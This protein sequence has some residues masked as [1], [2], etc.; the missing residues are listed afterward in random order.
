MIEGKVAR[1]LN[2]R[3]LVINRGARNGVEVGMKFAVLDKKAENI[4]DPETGEVLGSVQ[5]PKIR[6]RVIEVEDRMSVAR[7]YEMFGGTRG[8]GTVDLSVLFLGEP[9][10]PRSLKTDETTWAPITEA[11]SFVKTGD[12]V[13]QVADV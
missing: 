10:R 7:T 12:S 6:V 4:K 3:E 13:R 2:T 5:R 1:I 11:E 8:L 9:A